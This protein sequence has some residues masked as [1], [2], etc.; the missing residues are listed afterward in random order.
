MFMFFKRR[1]YR[2]RLP[3]ILFINHTIFVWWCIYFNC[4][5][6]AKAYHLSITI[7]QATSSHSY[8]DVTTASPFCIFLKCKT[9]FGVTHSFTNKVTKPV[10]VIAINFHINYSV[11][12]WLRQ[13]MV[14]LSIIKCHK[15]IC[16]CHKCKAQD[17][18]CKVK[19][20][21]FKIW[22]KNMEAYVSLHL[23]RILLQKLWYKWELLWLGFCFVFFFSSVGA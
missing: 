1:Y 9:T 15:Y 16:T 14:C 12:L 6:T 23:I 7:H 3:Y 21:T 2:K 10:S 11:T 19:S 20:P 4:Q 13:E 18:E 8:L 17:L 22:Q 5:I